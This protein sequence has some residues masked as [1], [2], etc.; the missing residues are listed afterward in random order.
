MTARN[1]E[2]THIHLSLCHHHSVIWGQPKGVFW[3]LPNNPFCFYFCPLRGATTSQG[4]VWMVITLLRFFKT[5]VPGL[6]CSSA[7]VWC[8]PEPVVSCSHL[9]SS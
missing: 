2:I 5:Y 7:A 3:G 1:L 4:T 8:W 9:K 6:L